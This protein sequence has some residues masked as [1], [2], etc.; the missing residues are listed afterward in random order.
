MQLAHFVDEGRGLRVPIHNNE[1]N[2]GCLVFASNTWS[3]N[4]L[5]NMFIKEQKKKLKLPWLKSYR[6]HVE[7]I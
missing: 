2:G 7:R 3:N 4:T 6:E 5:Q 1:D